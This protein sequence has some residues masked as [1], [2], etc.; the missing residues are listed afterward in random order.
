MAWCCGCKAKRQ[1]VNG[2][3]SISSNNRNMVKGQCSSC[4]GNMCE[5]VKGKAGGS[6]ML[7]GRGKGKGMCGK[8]KGK[9]PLGDLLGSFF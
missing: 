4:G 6:P 7:P 8:T 5:F 2:R 1:M 9:G 3:H